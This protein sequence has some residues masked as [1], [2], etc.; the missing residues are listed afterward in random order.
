MPTLDQLAEKTKVA[1]EL[2][3][4]TSRPKGTSAT[5][6]LWFVLDGQRLYILSAESSS[7]VWDVKREA[8]VEVAI[9]APTSSDRLAMQ[10]DIMTEESW[11]PMMIDLLQKKYGATH[12]ERMQRTTEAAKGGHVIIKLK[13]L[14]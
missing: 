12:G 4:T 3:M 8:K 6:P 1:E 5:Y 13:P 2:W 14:D 7:E 11:V 10:A 9:G